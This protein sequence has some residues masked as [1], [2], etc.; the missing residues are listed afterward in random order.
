MKKAKKMCALLIALSLMLATG[1]ANQSAGRN[2]TH[3]AAD[4]YIEK[5]QRYIDEKDYAAAIDILQLGLE[6]IDDEALEEMLDE[7]IELQIAD[8]AEDRLPEDTNNDADTEQQAFDISKYASTVTY[9]A[10]EGMDWVYGGYALGIYINEISP[11]SA[12][13][14][15]SYLQGAPSSRNAVAAAEIPL[16][17]IN[18][19]EVTYSFENDGWGHSGNV[20]LTFEDDT[21]LFAV[22]DVAYTDPTCP[23]MWGFYDVSGNLVSNPTIYNDLYYTEEEYNALFGEQ[24]QPPQQPVYDTSKASG[25]LASLG[26]TEQEFRTICTYINSSSYGRNEYA[27]A[28]GRQYYSEHPEDIMLTILDGRIEEW[29]DYLVNGKESEY[30]DDDSKWYFNNSGSLDDYLN[31]RFYGSKGASI[32]GEQSKAYFGDMLEYPNN[33]LGKAFLLK[34][35]IVEYKDDYTYYGDGYLLYDVPTAVIDRRD[36]VHSPNI[37]N[38]TQYDMYVLFQGTYNTNSGATGLLFH[39]ISVEK[40]D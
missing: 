34:D 32:L 28:A 38:K 40:S 4:M 24:E 9:W 39:L 2:D 12:Y 10:T 14:E 23:E 6:T 27:Y 36:D 22:S 31:L 19:N 8:T 20:T 30:Y 26:M 18:S 29:E 33:Y 17:E 11:N 16:S 25:I 21:I 5:V 13:F 37:L 15:F 1:C 7:V 35:F 3:A